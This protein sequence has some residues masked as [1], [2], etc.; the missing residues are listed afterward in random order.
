MHQLELGLPAQLLVERGERLV[1]QQHAR[2]LD[3][4]ARERDAL[5]LAAGQLVRLACGEAF[6]PDQRQHLGDA[7]RDLR[8]G[9]SILLEPERDIAR[10]GQMRKQRVALEHHVDRP[11]IGRHRRDILRRRAGCDRHPAS[12]SPASMRSSVVLPQPEGPSSAKNSPSKMSSDTPST[13]ATPEKRLLTPSNRTSGRAA[14]S[15]QG[16]NVRRVPTRM[17]GW[18]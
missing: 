18:F 8:L 10:D 15:L 1:E 13:A 7:R 6:E 12:R 4:R 14:G 9:Q 16:A 11:P 5:A 3:Q 17:L 2:P